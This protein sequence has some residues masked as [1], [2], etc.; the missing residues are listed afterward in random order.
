MTGSAIHVSDLHRGKTAD[1]AVDAAL[2]RL[3]D[4]MRPVLVL[5]TGDLSNRGRER[6][7][8]EAQALLAALGV[9]VLAVP[10]NHDIPYTFPA[11]FTR[12]WR[13]FERVFGT[14][15]P[16]FRSDAVVAVGLNSVWPTRQ[17]GGRLPE[18]QLARAHRELADAGPAALRLVALHH[19]LA[20]SPWRAAHKRPIKQ[21]DRA[22]A[23]LAAAGAELVLGG[24]IHQSSAVER[25]EFAVLDGASGASGASVVLATA[26]GYGRPRPR[27]TGEAHGLH[28]YRWDETQLVVETR[29]WDGSAFAPTAER[30][31]PRYGQLQ[32]AVVAGQ[33]RTP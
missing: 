3:V 27:R 20:G 14:V 2:Q 16:V 7:L 31:F 13:T 21:R 1:A 19:Q 15:E 33:E 18:A 5:A 22:L 12:P 25:H 23:G 11:R 8:A 17:Q 10:G 24:H 32:S 6:Q 9:P 26:P 30:S 4:E 29:I 28:V